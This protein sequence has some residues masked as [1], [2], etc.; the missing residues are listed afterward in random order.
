[1]LEA[2]S[3]TYR[4]WV[5]GVDVQGNIGEYSSIVANVDPPPDVN[6]LSNQLFNPSLGTTDNLDNKIITGIPCDEEDRTYDSIE[7]TNT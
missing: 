1:M 6:L 4:Y 3:A 5:A 2:E 7:V